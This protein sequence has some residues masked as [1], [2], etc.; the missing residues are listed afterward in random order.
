MSPRCETPIS[1]PRVVFASETVSAE[2]SRSMRMNSGRTA[3]SPRFVVV[4]TGAA[5]RTSACGEV[6]AAPDSAVAPRKKF[7]CPTKA[8]T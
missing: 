1:S 7:C 6:I 3:A 2:A 5:A 4:S 8:A